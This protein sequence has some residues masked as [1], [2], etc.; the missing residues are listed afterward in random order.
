MRQRFARFFRRH[1]LALAQF[2]EHFDHFIHTVEIFR[3]DNDRAVNIAAF[4][5]RGFSDFFFI[6]QKN[7]SQESP[8]QKTGSRFDNS[9]ILAFCEYDLFRVLLQLV[10]HLFKFKHDYPHFTLKNL[11]GN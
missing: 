7:W 10:Y 2:A 4:L 3:V 9:R 8:G 6:P 1:A 5:F 11:L